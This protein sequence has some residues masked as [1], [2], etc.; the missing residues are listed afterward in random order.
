MTSVELGHKFGIDL[1]W[2]DINVLH[3]TS[4]KYGRLFNGRR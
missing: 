4:P 1:L 3:W 2:G